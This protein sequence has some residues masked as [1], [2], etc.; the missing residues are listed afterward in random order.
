MDIQKP[1]LLLD[2]NKCR[3]NIKFMSDKANNNQINFRP[4]FKTHQSAEIGSW[5]KDLGI[6][7]ITVSSVQM[8]EYFANADWKDILIA[9]PVNILEID[10]INKLA[11][12]INL[13]LLLES[14]E[15]TKFLIDNLKFQSGIYLKIDT[16]YHRTGLS[17]DDTKNINEIISLVKNSK[18]LTFTGILTHAGHAYYAG[19]KKEVLEIHNYSIQQ[20]LKVKKL[21][22]KYYQECIISIGDTPT[23]SLATDFKGVD[24]IRPGNFVFYD[25][26]QNYLKSCNFNQIAVAFACPIVA[27][28][29]S[30]NEIVIYGGGIHFSK[31]AIYDNNG[32][33]IFGLI[34]KIHD[35]GWDKPLTNTYL[36]SISQEHGIIQTTEESFDLFNIGETVGILPVHSCLSANLMSQFTTLDNKKITK[37]RFKS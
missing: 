17:P 21:A 34:V 19:N 24:E 22:L 30:R 5:F 11:Q 31:E 26:M 4:H 18:Y 32:R 3:Q 28:H 14:V 16:G 25:V 6:T 37:F 8:A 13:H 15:A 36:S 27:R 29:K 10:S 1:T 7:S 9:F 2:E 20:L 23:C 12:K 33:K 35:K